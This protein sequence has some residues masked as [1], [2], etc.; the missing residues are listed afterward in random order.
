ML[1]FTSRGPL[2]P[3]YLGLETKSQFCCHLSCMSK[4]F[5]FSHLSVPVAQTFGQINLNV[6]LMSHVENKTLTKDWSPVMGKKT[7]YFFKKS[8]PINHRRE[9]TL[10]YL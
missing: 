5:N 4:E 2:T 10:Y 8:F 3:F 9:L 7:F 1:L 6:C